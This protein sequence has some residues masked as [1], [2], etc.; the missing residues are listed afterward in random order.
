[1]GFSGASVGFWDKYEYFAPG[2]SYII[3]FGSFRV[4]PFEPGESVENN[5]D[6]QHINHEIMIPHYNPVSKSEFVIISIQITGDL[7]IPVHFITGKTIV[8]LHLRQ[9]A[10]QKKILKVNKMLPVYRGV[11]HQY[12]YGLGS[13]FKTAL[14]TVTPLIKPLV[15]S[16]L[17][18]VKKEGIKQGIR[19]A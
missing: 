11:K 7:G 8:K 1:M 12:G 18:A 5:N 16:G 15:K 13:I 3:Y 19:A 9:R 6:C 4:L 17:N 14:K 2:L 10:T